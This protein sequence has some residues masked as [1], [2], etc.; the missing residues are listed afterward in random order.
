MRSEVLFVSLQNRRAPQPKNARSAAPVSM[1]AAIESMRRLGA[2]QAHAPALLPNAAL[3]LQED[4]HGSEPSRK[5]VSVLRQGW[6]GR[7]GPGGLE[8]AARLAGGSPD[9][10]VQRHEPAAGCPL[11]AV[12]RSHNLASLAK[13]CL[14]PTRRRLSVGHG[15]QTSMTHVAPGVQHDSVMIIHLSVHQRKRQRR[16]PADLLALQGSRKR[17]QRDGLTVRV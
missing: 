8:W 4:H 16:R 3:A 15:R 2:R 11:A 12:W 14:L 7:A 5:S 13:R 6:Q 9:R 17:W 1:A 10:Q